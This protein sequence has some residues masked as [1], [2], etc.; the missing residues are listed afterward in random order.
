MFKLSERRGCGDGPYCGPEGLFLG[1][2]A[3]VEKVGGRYRTRA[4][5]DIKALLAAHSR[6]QFLAH[7]EIHEQAL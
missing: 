5:D 7:P 1:S 6:E 3:L 2:I 4:P